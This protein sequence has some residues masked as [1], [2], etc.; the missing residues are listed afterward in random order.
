MKPIIKYGSTRV[1][2]GRENKVD[3]LLEIEAPA[4]PTSE[5]QPLDVVA[6]IDR[7]GSM[8]GDPLQ[9]VLRAVAQLLRLADKDDRIGVVVFDDQV[10]TIV[11]LESHDDID[12]MIRR[13]MG[14]QSGGMT[15]LSGGWL[16]AKSMLEE[17]GRPQALKRI[18]VLTDGHANVGLSTVEAFGPAVVT[19]RVAGIT[20]SCIGFADGYDEEFL[21]GVADAGS[22]NDYFCAGPDQAM[23]V[24]ADEFNGLA[25]VVAQ[26]LDVVVTLAGT[27]R[28]VKVRHDFPVEKIDDRRTRI[29]LGDSYGGET[30]KVLLTWKCN[31]R[32]ALGPVELGEI[33][34]NWV[35]VIGEPVSH[36]ITTAVSVDVVEDATVGPDPGA[37]PEVHTVAELMR[38]E[39][40]RRNA[41]RAADAGDFRNA[42]AHFTLAEAL[43]TSLGMA[44]E[45]RV[46][47][48]DIDML[49]SNSWSPL[50][51]KRAF[52]RGRSN[53]KGRKS[54]YDPSID[55]QSDDDTI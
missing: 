17:S 5:R 35:S 15:N 18:I 20:T 27:T 11:P 50:N 8:S 48:D 55:D 31:P 43:F 37:S 25:S 40:E 33:T 24:F 26:N 9:S 45:S 51:S 47:A 23:A 38:A 54:S 4:A 7:S 21:A 22:G 46:V 3:I 52:S 53:N 1:T 19:G 29:L 13:I 2:R 32:E 14:V 41:R 49:R 28:K 44:A 34:V 39:R 36:S 42:E 10:E 16:R 30:R 6:V 12:A